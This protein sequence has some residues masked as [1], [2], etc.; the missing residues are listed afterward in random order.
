MNSSC[1]WITSLNPNK[2]NG[3]HINKNGIQNMSA[4]ILCYKIRVYNYIFLDVLFIII[5]HNDEENRPVCDKFSGLE[6]AKLIILFQATL[7]N[8]A[9]I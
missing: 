9:A 7:I 8:P 6:D 2:L 5:I 3:T 4:L 1:F